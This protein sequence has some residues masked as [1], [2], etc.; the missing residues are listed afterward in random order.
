[1]QKFI[2]VTIYTLLTILFFPITLLGYLIWV[3]GLLRARRS[4]ISA[5]AQGPLSARWVQHKLGVRRDEVAS[6]LL[7]ALPG[8]SPLAV[9]MVFA[10]TL[11]AHRLTGFVPAT[12]RYPFRGEMTLQ[13][14]ASARQSL[15]DAVVDQYI[16]DMDQFVILGAGFDTRANRLVK[17]DGLRCFEVDTPKTLGI[18]Q[19][20]L[21]KIKI[22][23]G[24]VTFVTADFNQEDWLI[25]LQKAGFDSNKPTLFLW[26]GVTPYLERSAVEDTLRKVATTARGSI[27]AFDYFTSEVLESQ[28][29]YLRMVRASL[30]AGGEPLRFAIDSTPPVRVQLEVLLDSC[31]LSLDRNATLGQETHGKH[32]LGGFATAIVR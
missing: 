31:D 11:I 4:G 17:R 1:M 13:N 21:A 6:Q 16:D 28:S 27:I 20:L 8:V 32:A 19:S 12:F 29:P 7:L 14:Q 3:I 9:W 25:P 10:P 30:N 24:G 22:D 5:T 18:K 15:Y 26:E 2:G 23:T